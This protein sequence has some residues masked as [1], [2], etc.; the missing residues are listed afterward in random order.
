MLINCP[1]CGATI[2]DNANDCPSCG[3]PLKQQPGSSEGCFLQTLNVGCVIIAIIAGIIVLI[4]IF[5]SL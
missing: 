1:E 5:S 2:S 4:V 3:Y